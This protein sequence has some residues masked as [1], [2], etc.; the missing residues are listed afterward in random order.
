MPDRNAGKI[1]RAHTRI[2]KPLRHAQDVG[3]KLRVGDALVGVD[4]SS[5][6]G[7]RRG[8]ASYDVGEAPV[9][10]GGLCARCAQICPVWRAK[11]LH[12][13]RSDAAVSFSLRN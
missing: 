7:N 4:D 12:A 3:P 8:V 1:T 13:A 10:L 2:P 9:F 11:D 5:G 6:A